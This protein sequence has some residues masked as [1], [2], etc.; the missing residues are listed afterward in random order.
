MH[1]LFTRTARTHAHMRY[2]PDEGALTSIEHDS[3]QIEWHQVNE[4]W[5]GSN[6]KKNICE[7][8]VLRDCNISH[9]ASTFRISHHLQCVCVD[10]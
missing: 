7:R 10:T 2:T 9:I 4:W 5:A 6:V 8:E 1:A 3:S